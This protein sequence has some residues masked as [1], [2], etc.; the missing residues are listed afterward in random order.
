MT[1]LRY[2]LV[3]SQRKVGMKQDFIPDIGKLSMEERVRLLQGERFAILHDRK[4]IFGKWPKAAL[5]AFSSVFHDILEA[6]PTAAAIVLY[7]IQVPI[8]SLK[9]L[10]F[11][12]AASIRSSEHVNLKPMGTLKENTKLYYT[13]SL[14][15]WS[16]TRATYLDEVFISI[17]ADILNPKATIGESELATIFCTGPD[18][19][20]YEFVRIMVPLARFP[21]PMDE[22]FEVEQHL[23]FINP[24]DYG[25]QITEGELDTILFLHNHRMQI[26]IGRG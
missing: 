4:V 22:I 1:R 16:P 12:M 10:L 26:L 19:L 15:G 7:S 18:D 11:F 6:N 21:G 17:G 5:M 20:L 9:Q 14:L 23:D 13:G 24:K 8:N 3:H 2:S 25:L